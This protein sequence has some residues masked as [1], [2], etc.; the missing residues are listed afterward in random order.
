M[1][2]I[3]Y[4]NVSLET[5]GGLL[6]LVFILCLYVPRRKKRLM[7]QPYIRMLV[8]N[9][10]LLFC[11]A[12]AWLFKGRPDPFSFYAVRVANFAVFVLGYVLLALFTHY[13]VNFLEE[14]G[15][16]RIR[17]PV[18]LMYGVMVLGIVLVVV[19]QFN[20]MY[21]FIDEQNV[22]HRGA[23][24][25]LSQVFGMAG[26]ALNSALL[27]RFR[28]YLKAG[29]RVTFW[30]YITLPVTALMFQALFYGIAVLYLATTA[31]LL[32]VYISIQVE[33][34]READ[35][36]ELELEKSRTALMLSQ[37]QPHFLYNSLDCIGELCVTDPPRAERAVT[38]FSIFLRG[39]IDALSTPDTIAFA[40]ELAHTQH[41]LELEQMR[42][43]TRLRVEYHIEATLFRLPPL[44]LQPIVENAVRYGVSAKTEGG[45]VTITT[46]ETDSD[47]IITV[48]D[49]GIGFDP[50]KILSDRRSHV[51]I[52]NVR[53]R[54]ESQ[55]GGTLTVTGAPGKGTKAVI[56]IP[57]PL[58]IG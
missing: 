16:P 30:V 53:Q 18:R 4:I 37:I 52:Q 47:W 13:L 29:E 2:V 10:I 25:W 9:T 27:L 24:F 42:F 14:K 35:Q 33:R 15:V 20:H 8:C 21:Y 22:Y 3:G 38:E 17:M 58:T 39:N 49:D 26:L 51:G 32:C 12:A 50:E 41:Y 7:E 55:C 43:D 54:L 36:R 6:S 31:C 44:T 19:S 28:R 5:F 1:S 57:K 11:D 40:Q 45:T 23:W 48:E 46:G 56:S 34:T